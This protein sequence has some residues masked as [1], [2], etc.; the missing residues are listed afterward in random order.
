LP[1]YRDLSTNFAGIG[2]GAGQGILVIC[3]PD[4]N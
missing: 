4:K 1:N 3:V 2:G